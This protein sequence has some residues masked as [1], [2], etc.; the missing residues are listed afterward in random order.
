MKQ[1]HLAFSLWALAA[2]QLTFA[3]SSKSTTLDF[4]FT[5][6]ATERVRNLAYVQLKPEARANPRPSAADFNII[7]VRVN[8]Q[9]R[10]DLYHYEGPAPM[11]FVLINGQAPDQAVSRVVATINQAASNQRTF[12]VLAP[13][14]SDDFG[15]M[16]VDDSESAFPVRHA[17]LLNLSGLAVS[18]S[19]DG[20][21]FA[22]PA[23]PKTNNPVAIDAS[24]RL[25][26]TYERLG[27]PVVVFDQTLDVAENERLLL[28][29]LP[30]FRPGAD[31]RTR[32]VRD[33]LVVTP[34]ETP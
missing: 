3:Q 28:V 15:I 31:V 21:L 18:G 25:G 29:F 19:L 12:V 10:S 8:S 32:V 30:P 13:S 34:K 26:V 17:R 24:V 27:R 14:E 7:P 11:R 23:E 2:A 1:L 5:I 20:K 22:L 4:D 33:Q 6:M 16:T 9:G